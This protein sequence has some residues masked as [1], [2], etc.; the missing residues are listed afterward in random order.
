MGGFGLTLG[1]ILASTL[2]AFSAGCGFAGDS[3]NTPKPDAMP[4][5]IPDAGVCTAAG[6]SCAG[7]VLRE[8]LA[9]NPM[10]IDHP[11]AWGCVAEPTAHCGELEP[12]GGGSVLSDDLHP[13]TGLADITLGSAGTT[14]NADT[15]EIKDGDGTKIRDGGE[16][17][18]AGI[19]FDKRDSGGW[20]V[21]T[22][23]FN[24]LTITA[25]EVNL[26]GKAA[27]ALVAVTTIEVSGL[28]DAQGDCTNRTPGPG[29]GQGGDREKKGDGL[30][31]GGGGVHGCAG[32]GGGGHGANGGYGGAGTPAGTKFG[33]PLIPT[34]I[35]GSGGGG[36]GSADG[37]GNGGVGGGGGGALHLAANQ[38]I[39]I[40]GPGIQAGG[41]GGKAAAAC[42]GGGGAGG[43]ILLEAP[44]IE[45]TAAATLA[46]NGGAGAGGLDGEAGDDGALSAIVASGGAGG[47]QGM[48]TNHGGDGGMGGAGQIYVGGNA[49]SP[50]A[51]AGGGGGAVGRIR[52]NTAS[53]SIVVGGATLSPPLG[54]I[55]ST[56]TQDMAA[57]K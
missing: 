19:I 14:I 35:G 57:T 12:A 22:F 32:G 3:S 42:G 56:T 15:G 51:A 10:A 54:A 4:D 43:A 45:L 21:G 52:F 13:M 41:C 30:G 50:G 25:S 9:G 24:R 53:G 47:G 55:D 33:G 36:G 44:I 48:G 20:P 11:C 49:P 23:R 37:V 39:T 6:M 31:G 1:V 28:L 27:V 7:L 46:V 5:A 29:G 18:K 34:L 8:C 38:R 26:I 16:G 40:N 17:L 2:L